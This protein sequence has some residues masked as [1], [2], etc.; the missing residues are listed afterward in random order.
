VRRGWGLDL[1]PYREADAKLRRTETAV[2]EA[3][4]PPPSSS[5]VSRT[6]AR[7]RAGLWPFWLSIIAV[8]AV[9]A[10]AT[11]AF[12]GI[13][14]LALGNPRVQTGAPIARA[15]L[16][17]LIKLALI[18]TAGIGGVLGL[19][20]T[21]RRQRIAEATFDLTK[22][23]QQ[24]DQ[25]I[26]QSNRVLQERVALENRQ[27]ASEQLVTSLYT[28]AVEQLGS[29][30]A[31]VRLAALYSLERIAQSNP[32]SRQPVVDVL[33]AYLRLP[34]TPKETRPGR[35][36]RRSHSELIPVFEET[37]V[38]MSVQQVLHR[39]LV[40]PGTDVRSRR[41][42]KFEMEGIRRR[43]LGEFG[44]GV[45][46]ADVDRE[47]EFWDDMHLDLRFA[48]LVNLELR[49]ARAASANLSE[50]TFHGRADFDGFA[51]TREA[52]FVRA[53]FYGPASFGGCRFGGHA[54]FYKTRFKGYASFEGC[55]FDHDADF[56][57]ASFGNICH[58]TEA[59][60]GGNAHFDGVTFRNKVSFNDARFEQ[61]AE[62]GTAAFWLDSI[63]RK[64][65]QFRHESTF[66]GANFH[67]RVAFVANTFLR[68]PSFAG[69]VVATGD[70]F[71]R[72]PPGVAVKN[73]GSE[74]S[75]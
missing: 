64:G 7:T 6:E 48:N 73:G 69:T 3:P 53:R 38:R 61:S 75:R 25:D 46:A 19:L 56:V 15:D 67:G 34:F 62:F 12:I 60:F 37:H 54:L 41:L 65:T 49:G 31:V 5:S 30:R 22:E 36:E 55:R 71:R 66:D 29:E 4:A 35:T 43:M 58:M 59:S 1:G 9:G 23:A 16:I 44:D 70:F 72:W 45:L 50:A 40:P 2:T 24:F 47:G 26:K 18:G 63:R 20:I 8:F 68:P 32:A 33:C 57:D 28:S 27:D 74:P 42:R 21:Y 17:D 10:T 51:T 11:A 52:S 14:L 13:L 39:H